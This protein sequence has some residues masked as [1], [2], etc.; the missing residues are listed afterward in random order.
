VGLE[1]QVPV[2]LTQKSAIRR[3]ADEFLQN[4]KKTV[5]LLYTFQR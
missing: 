4:L 2:M 3:S 1:I 5:K